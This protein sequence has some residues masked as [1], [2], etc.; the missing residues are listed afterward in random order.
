M[1]IFNF[2]RGRPASEPASG[3]R[4][5]S[6]AATES[7]EMVRKRARQR[8]IGS[9]VLVLVGVVG[10]PLLFE[11]QPRPVPVDI[12]IEIPSRNSV[13]PGSPIQPVGR[14]EPA[15]AEPEP[16]AKVPA[17][18][19]A[20]APS[21]SAPAAASTLPPQASLQEREEII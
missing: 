10:F 16:A 18:L 15:P 17:Q 6:S 7:V 2:R 11:T 19:Q 9:A 4:A 12:A 20:P 13:K 1:S 8:L 3:A 14:Q 5:A 21:A